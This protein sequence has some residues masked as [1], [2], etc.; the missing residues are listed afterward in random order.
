MP[1]ALVLMIV[2]MVM[3]TVTMA[4]VVT[5]RATGSLVG[6][7][8]RLVRLSLQEALDFSLFLSNKILLHG[9]LVVLVSHQ[10]FE[11]HLLLEQRPLRFW[12]SALSTVS[13][14]GRLLPRSQSVISAVVLVLPTLVSDVIDAQHPAENRGAAQIVDGQ[15]GAALVF[16]LQKRKASALACLLVAHE[17]HMDGLAKLREY[18]HYIALGQIVGQAANVDV[19]GVPVVGVPG[20]AGRAALRQWT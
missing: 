18:R 7:C 4:M 2:V 16:V 13:A 12:Q 17:I 8:H 19:C 3:V 6:A 10:R 14:A 15:V 20:R 9:I 11:L 5:V 1:P